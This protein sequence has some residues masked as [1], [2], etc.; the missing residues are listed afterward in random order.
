MSIVLNA[1]LQEVRENLGKIVSAIR[2]KK[3]GDFA[4]SFP[5]ED[6]VIKAAQNYVAVKKQKKGGV[7]EAYNILAATVKDLENH[8]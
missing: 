1:R 4:Y 5:F 7:N 6:R 8:S 3:T 2:F